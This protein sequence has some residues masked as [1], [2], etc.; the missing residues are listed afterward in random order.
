MIYGGMDVKV[1]SLPV[2]EFER[3]RYPYTTPIWP[4]QS[5]ENIDFGLIRD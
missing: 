2:K 5:G 3:E 1:A 4:L